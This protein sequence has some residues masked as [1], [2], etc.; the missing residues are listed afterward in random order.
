MG[1]E[2][3]LEASRGTAGEYSCTAESAGFAPL[4]GRVHLR[5]RGPPEIAGFAPG[6]VLRAGE[7]RA[8]R[9]RVAGGNPR[10]WVAWYRHGPGGG[11]EE[12]VPPQQHRPR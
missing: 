12:V 8:L 5:L 2:L 7:R 10:P 6:A 3:P 1:E 11:V 9:C 4:E